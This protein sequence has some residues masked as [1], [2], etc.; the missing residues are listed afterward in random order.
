MELDTIL[1]P[2]IL[3][4]LCLFGSPDQPKRY[5][6]Y[7]QDG[8]FKGTII[9][10]TT[11]TGYEFYITQDG[12]EK[13]VRTYIQKGDDIFAYTVKDME[14]ATRELNLDNFRKPITESCKTG[15]RT[16][17][18]NGGAMQMIESDKVKYVELGNVVFAVH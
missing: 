3:W 13:L 1:I 17:D 15:T 12:K 16:I 14:G 9:V 11:K 10:K 2:V 6:D 8:D 4:I 7:F 5:I 18:I